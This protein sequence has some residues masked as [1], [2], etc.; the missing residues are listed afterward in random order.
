MKG[1]LMFI[2]NEI[3]K[4]STVI[5]NQLLSLTLYLAKLIPHKAWV[6]LFENL[7]Y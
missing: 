6:F 4:K 7:V 1:M 2:E 5:Q 3:E